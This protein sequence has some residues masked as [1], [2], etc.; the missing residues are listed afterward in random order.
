MD[1]AADPRRFAT[2][3]RPPGLCGRL[4]GPH[5]KSPAFLRFPVDTDAV[6]LAGLLQ[7]EAHCPTDL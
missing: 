1:Q 6:G 3:S 2:G 7:M 4:R 5:A